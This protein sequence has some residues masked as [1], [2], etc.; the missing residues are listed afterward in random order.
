MDEARC[1]G[2]DRLA[3]PRPGPLEAG[4][5]PGGDREGDANGYRRAQ[6]PDREA[7]GREE[8]QDEGAEAGHEVFREVG[9]LSAPPTANAQT[10]I[11][12]VPPCTPPLVGSLPAMDPELLQYFDHVCDKIAAHPSYSVKVENAARA[13]EQFILN[14][15]THGPGQ[16]YCVS[17]CVRNESLAQFGLPAPQEE[18]A[19]IRAIGKTSEDCGPRMEAFAARLA[20]RYGL[21]RMPAV[22]LDGVPFAGR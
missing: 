8:A 11:A 5:A 9:R 22:F 2:E 19:H 7:R 1:P 4:S 15:H 12:R 21:K 20:D 10:R 17:V 18:L 16:D 3:R 13:G 6:A 14:Y